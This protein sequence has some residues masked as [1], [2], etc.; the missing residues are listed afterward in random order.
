ML[1]ARLQNLQSVKTKVLAL[2]GGRV[3]AVIS[4]GWRYAL[5]EGGQFR[6]FII[7]S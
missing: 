6:H 2:C 1:P 3:F 4:A 7:K 5:Y